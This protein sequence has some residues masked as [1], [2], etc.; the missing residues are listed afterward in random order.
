MA[1]KFPTPQERA[2]QWLLEATEIAADL[3]VVFTDGGFLRREEYDGSEWWEYEPPFRG[4]ETQK[5]FRLV[6]LTYF[7]DSLEDINYP[8]EATEE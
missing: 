3:V 5:P 1:E 7:A 6:K 2:M 4:P 8:M